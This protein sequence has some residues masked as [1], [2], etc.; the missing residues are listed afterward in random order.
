MSTFL[1]KGI[2]RAS[3]NSRF[4]TLPSDD[5]SVGYFLRNVINFQNQR[6]FLI[7]WPGIPPRD[8]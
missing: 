1:E 8:K 7:E 3:V 5:Y 2:T 4:K 6:K